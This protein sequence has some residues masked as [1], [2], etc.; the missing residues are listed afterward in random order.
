M[1]DSTVLVHVCQDVRVKRLLLVLAA[2]ICAFFVALLA[3]HERPAFSGA[4]PPREAS[5][6]RPAN[7]DVGAQ[8]ALP[9]RSVSEQV[10]ARR[11][12]AQADLT[13]APAL[14][15]N[16]LLP[17][18]VFP[19]DRWDAGQLRLLLKRRRNQDLPETLPLQDDGAVLIAEFAR[20][21][22]NSLEFEVEIET[23]DGSWTSGRARVHL[24]ERKRPVLTVHMQEIG[25]LEVDA[26]AAGVDPR[27]LALSLT[28]EPYSV[29]TTTF[30]SREVQ[31][32]YGVAKPELT[33][34]RSWRVAR[35]PVKTYALR[36]QSPRSTI[37]TAEATLSTG[38]TTRV[39]M[40]VTALPKGGDLSVVI[41]GRGGE[42]PRGRVLVRHASLPHVQFWRHV[43]DGESDSTLNYTNL[44]AGS[45]EVIPYPALGVNVEPRTQTV[46]VPSPNIH[47]AVLAE[48]PRRA[49]AVEA[50]DAVTN[51]PIKHV[52]VWFERPDGRIWKRRFTRGEEYVTFPEGGTPS[53]SAK[54][55]GYGRLPLKESDCRRLERRPSLDGKGEVDVWIADA[56]LERL[57]A[58]QTK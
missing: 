8:L 9:E 2:L 21:V 49:M 43:Q 36:L 56:A 55:K 34:V 3:K 44:P 39:Q 23:V 54:S 32:F 47:F 33:S 5:T 30:G 41:E 15:R 38:R 17:I 20:S 53:F 11:V 27:Q 52:W 40:E 51:E 48:A 28:P 10:E 19:E 31:W 29:H 25:H 42:L 24:L 6:P 46:D 14:Q 58:A 50:V 18:R 12:Q 13:K 7:L 16:I 26:A 1:G 4:P 35:I 37:S 22:D 45:Y 57:E